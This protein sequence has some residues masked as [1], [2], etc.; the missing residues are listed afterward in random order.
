MRAIS[1]WLDDIKDIFKSRYMTAAIVAIIMIPLV[2]GGVY[3]AAF[4]DPYGN[5]E[6][7]PVVVVNLDEGYE[8]DDGLF[9]S[10]GEELVNALKYNDDLGWNFETDLKSA[11]DG[12]INDSYYAMF[13]IPEDFSTTLEQLKDGKLKQPVIKFIPNEKKNYIV[14]LI[15]K[16]A[17]TA[18]ESSISQNISGIFTSVVF[19]QLEYLKDK[20]NMASEAVFLLE[21]GVNTL[22]HSIPTLQD[23]LEKIS[24]G[25]SLMDE[26]LGDA[27]D[28]VTKLNDAIT[29]IN[30]KMP[31]LQDGA[32][33]LSKGTEVFEEKLNT[34]YEGVNTLSDAIDAYGS[35][36]PQIQDAT[37][38][39]KD[40]SDKI[41]TNLDTL[42]DKSKDVRVAVEAITGGLD[43]LLSGLQ[44]AADGAN[45]LTQKYDQVEDGF[46]MLSELQIENTKS[47]MAKLL[48]TDTGSIYQLSSGANTIGLM[49][50]KYGTMGNNQTL[51]D[52]GNAIV[53]VTND[54]NNIITKN[55]P[56][57]VKTAG[58]SLDYAFGFD[59]Y[60]FE[61]NNFVSD[62]EAQ[63]NAAY[64]EIDKRVY[65]FATDM[66]P[67][68]V[69]IGKIIEDLNK[70]K[71]SIDAINKTKAFDANVDAVRQ[72]QTV[73]LKIDDAIAAL[74]PQI[75]PTVQKAS[76]DNLGKLIKG[77]ASVQAYGSNNKMLSI[78]L[79]RDA[80]AGLNKITDGSHQLK[81]N[82]PKFENSVSLLSKYSGY[83]T[84]NLDKLDSKIPDLE[85]GMSL[86]SDN[87]DLLDDGMLKLHGASE[88]LVDGAN[89]LSSK[90]PDLQEGISMI[91]D[92]SEQVKEGL[93]KLHSASGL[94]ADG[95]ATISEKMPDLLDGVNALYDGTSALAEK[96]D[97]GSDKI[98]ESVVMDSN[99]MA[100]FMND[101]ITIEKEEA[102]KVENYGTGFTPYFISLA[103]WVGALTMFFIIPDTRKE[104][105]TVKEYVFGKY[106][107]YGTVGVI[108]AVILSIVIIMLG[109]R[110]YSY[111]MYF[112]FN[113]MLSLVFV[114]IM[115]FLIHMFK[116]PGRLC[117][118]VFLLL[119]LTS[120]GG[121][122]S[123]EL[124]PKFFQVISPFMPFT[125]SVNGLR[126]IISG[127]NPSVL[128]K[129]VA[130]L[131]G[132]QV[133][134]LAALYIGMKSRDDKG[135]IKSEEVQELRIE[136][137][138]E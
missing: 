63:L 61:K 58:D 32:E 27:E 21:D 54:I 111:V 90:V 130:V 38:D 110:P 22:D 121:T 74:Q 51:I 135:M 100:A 10:H 13:V 82:M 84:L 26:K 11:Q 88:N 79:S 64:A 71:I 44:T 5:T 120:C 109:L 94:L 113:I 81:K 124:L 133:V 116:D 25:S 24:D 122:F 28:G 108:Q 77:K 129:C 4:W 99:A 31:Q 62:P 1:I 40:S 112:A 106:M 78:G 127:P 47:G 35:K 17:S 66:A 45:T 72:I 131:V 9:V 101:P 80:V 7:L 137:V 107:T 30:D 48:S 126:E 119:Q 60:E 69:Y 76:L 91:N 29:A 118:T 114:A 132:V 105:T 70:A 138:T 52:N 36:I 134:S 46:I 103:L 125:Y 89:E 42:A 117:A 92:G 49:A 20:L 136:A 16:K 128:F 57:T 96:L 3:L 65:K 95:S 8:I 55:L 15:N 102:Y 50:V 68:G 19:E 87:V 33:E 98:S 37:N 67:N 23:G 75:N 6:D 14:S 104:G 93:T 83:L 39:L 85:Q 123:V 2:Y 115:Q 97:E 59:Y 43:E 53:N 73:Y 41:T 12:L 34:A 86:I 56:V 18:L